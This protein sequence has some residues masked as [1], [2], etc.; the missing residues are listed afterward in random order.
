M[1]K[2]KAWKHMNTKTLGIQV[3]KSN[4]ILQISNLTLEA[5]CVVARFLE[6]VVASCCVTTHHIQQVTKLVHVTIN[7][8]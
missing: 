6:V 5:C 4:I 8:H 2:I 7:Y 3:F 1:V